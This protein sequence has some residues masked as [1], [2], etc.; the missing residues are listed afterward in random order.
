MKIL[1]DLFLA[2]L[3]ATLLLIAVCLFLLWQLSKTTEDVAAA[4]AENLHVLEPVAEEIGGLRGDLA[5]LRT[6]LGTL[7]DT[8]GE[9]A[10]AKTARI[11]ARL[12]AFATRLDQVQTRIDNVAAEPERL[13]SIAVEAAS[14]KAGQT[15]LGLR[16]CKPGGPVTPATVNG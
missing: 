12:D 1:K 6:E 2:M 14:K 15:L 8:T 4:F 3:N 13:M 10:G 7:G 9:A 16:G 11:E 5:A